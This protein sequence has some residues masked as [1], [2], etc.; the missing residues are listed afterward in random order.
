MAK[1]GKKTGREAQLVFE[2]LSIEGGL[3]SPEWLSK[4][5]QLSAGRQT[6]ADYRV[7]KGLNLRD[8]IGRYWRIAQAHWSEF[9][10]GLK[11]PADRT[12]LA[13]RFVTSVLRD[14]FGFISLVGVAPATVADRTFSLGHAAMHGRVPV[15]I[16]PAASGVDTLAQEFGDQNRRRSA[17]GLAQEYLN[18]AQEAV[19]GIATDGTTLRIVRD[20][21]SLTRPA[22]IEVDLGRIFAEERYADFA[23]LWLLAHETRFGSDSQ[24]ST[25][26]VLE[27]W[28]AAGR[29]EGTRAREH[30]R[31]GVEEALT[32][33]GQG[34]LAQNQP[35]RAALQDGSLTTRDYFG[36]L[37]RLVYRLIF[38]LTVEERNLL[39]PEG[40]TEVVRSLY[41][42][43]YSL[44]RLC[45]K[46]VKRSAH[47]RF[48]DH[49]ESLQVVLRGLGGGE[50]RIGLPALAGIFASKHCRAIDRAQLENRFLLLALY[51]LA[52]LRDGGAL[53]R[54]NWRDMGP[55]ELGSV[56]ESLL[57]L[58]PKVSVDRREFGFAPETK[59]PN[60]ARRDTSSYYTHDSLVQRLL[61]TAL[62]PVITDTLNRNPGKPVEALLGLSIIDPACGSGHFLLA[63]AR[64]LATHVARLQVNGTPSG[65]EYR[66]A[67][68]QV[69]GR[70]IYGVDL[71]PMAVELCK[72][73]LWMEAVEPGLPLTFLNSHIQHGNALLGALPEV[74]EKGVPDAA[75]NPIDGDDIDVTKALKRR[76]KQSA[77]GQRSL[78]TLWAPPSDAE[79][80]SVTKAV[81]ELEEASDADVAGLISK[82][83]KWETILDLPEYRHQKFVADAWCAA[84][85]WPKMAGELGNIAPTNELWLQL[86]DGQ[87]RPPPLT[88]Q[89]VTE[90]VDQYR[91]F[92]WNLQFPHVWRK[93][94]F[95]VVLGNPPWDEVQFE[96][97]AWFTSRDENIAN[98]QTA[99]ER[100]QLIAQLESANPKLF[101]EYRKALRKVDGTKAFIRASGVFP[102]GSSGKLNT[103][104]LFTAR[105]AN[106]HEKSRGMFGLVVPTGVVTDKG[107]SDLFEA[108]MSQGR[109]RSVYDFVNERLL[110]PAVRPH[111]HFCLLTG[112]GP[113]L[114]ADEENQTEIAAFLRDTTEVA[115]ENRRYRLDW[116][117]VVALNPEA[118]AIPLFSSRSEAEASRKLCGRLRPIGSQTEGEDWKAIYQQ[119]TF[120]T[121]AASDLFRDPLTLAESGYQ[122]HGLLMNKDGG[123]MYVPLFDAKMARQFEWRAASVGFSGNRFR[124][125][126]KTAASSEELKDPDYLPD[127]AFWVSRSESDKRLR[128]WRRSW[129]LGFK[130]VTGVTSTRLAA[131]AFVPRMGFADKYPLLRLEYDAREHAFV[132]GWLN[133]LVVEWFL[134]QRMHGVSLTWHILSQIPIPERAIATS[135]CA[136]NRGVTVAQ[137]FATRIAELSCTSWHLSDLALELI[138]QPEA[139]VYDDDRRFYIRAEVEA[140]CFYLAGF[141]TDQALFVLDSL[142]KIAARETSDFGY[143][144]S[145]EEIP[146]ILGAIADAAREGFIYQTDLN[147]VPASFRCTQVPAL[148][149]GQRGALDSAPKFLL[150]FVYAFLRQTR[151]EATFD[152]LDSVFHLLRHR[153]HHTDEFASVLGDRAKRWGSTFNDQL[154][155]KEFVPFL[156]R[157]E[158]DGWIKVDRATGHLCMTEKFPAVPFDAWRNF[159][160]SAALR[161]LANKPELVQF[162][163]TDSSASLASREFTSQK[164]G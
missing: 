136:W 23:A 102:V 12:A 64:R 21:A 71:N 39:H 80:Q 66:H 56:Y 25:D 107:A 29:E 43:G 22:W 76:N 152:L 72:V 27:A 61:D 28:R 96:E 106:L 42:K 111:Q 5:A 7:P 6:E 53:T 153:A 84:F 1:Q 32:A 149:H 118:R 82:E 83:S 16:A 73:S 113:R 78:D 98:S 123:E 57:E 36:Q 142:I 48:G 19:W 4:V 31:R 161:V 125:I 131:F 91:F 138:G 89:V 14:C 51:K 101:L 41:A 26:C 150:S 87:G 130:D 135:E 49:W 15:V 59:A 92:H 86:R 35:L 55:E 105:T 119:G 155:N 158:A 94:G 133:S 58:E 151:A 140:A 62:E 52:W 143:Y 99:A 44:R 124:K 126:S 81:S 95:D 160:V 148:P 60:T 162:I 74:M 20:N 128:E 33:L 159:D 63:A 17:F 163:L 18:A 40:T 3:L 50:P 79:V 47:D 2:A 97:T 103:S 69:V 137:W 68:R 127:F 116:D 154:P 38:L 121:A 117:Q 24:P 108:L 139:F 141:N 13:V 70:C 8:E 110:F 93:G 146:R 88:I 30:L 115:N 65:T 156:K 9:S 157:L 120:N 54:V 46:S 77:S 90:L 112:S 45:A 145:R 100:A 147:P 132:A 122:R 164:V 10:A 75:W 134:R 37:L 34:F 144:R 67:L 104:T 85:V 114:L 109:L 11:A 129:L